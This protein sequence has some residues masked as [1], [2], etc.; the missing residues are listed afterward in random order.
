M[1]AV[2]DHTHSYRLALLGCGL[3]TAAAALFLL[4]LR[5]YP[6]F[7]PQAKQTEGATA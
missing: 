6:L 1:G 3:A 2:F 7:D 4:R 5:T